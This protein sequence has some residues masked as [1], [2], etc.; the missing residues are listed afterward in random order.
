MKQALINKYI[1]GLSTHKEEMLLKSLLQQI[2]FEKLSSFTES[3]LRTPSTYLVTESI[4][5]IAGS[6][7]PV[8]I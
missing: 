7:P 5:T 8:R 2:P 4:S 3:S 6:S 1:E